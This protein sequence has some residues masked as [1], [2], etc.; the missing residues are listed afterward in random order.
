MERC[1]ALNIYTYL[2]FKSH[3][4]LLFFSCLLDAKEELLLS[5][6]YVAKAN[7]VINIKL[8]MYI[9]NWFTVFDHVV[10][11]VFVEK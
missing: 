7:E 8:G 4:L 10:V 9:I 1:C 5:S 11:V 3:P 2:S 6:H